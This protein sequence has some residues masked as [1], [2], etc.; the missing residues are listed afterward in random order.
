MSSIITVGGGGGTTDGD[1]VFLTYSGEIL[2]KTTAGEVLRMRIPNSGT[3][4]VEISGDL[5]LTAGSQYKING[6]ALTQEQDSFVDGEVVSG[7]KDGSNLAFTTAFVPVAGSVH[8]YLNGLLQTVS[9]DYTISGNLIT[10][11]VAP[12]SDDTLIA[13]YR[14]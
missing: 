14:K 5:N 12:Q 2:F 10:M 7:T 3:P 6:V 4:T 9:V 11:T 1:I 8:L 13:S